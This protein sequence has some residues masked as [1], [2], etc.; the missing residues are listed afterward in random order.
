MEKARG[1]YS[2]EEV[3]LEVFPRRDSLVEGGK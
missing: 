2:Q 1:Q 3:G